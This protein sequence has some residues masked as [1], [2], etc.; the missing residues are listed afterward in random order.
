MAKK[1]GQVMSTEPTTVNRS[2]AVR[3][4]AEL[5]SREDV[6]SLEMTIR[7]RG[8]PLRLRVTGRRIRVTAGTDTTVP[9]DLCC[10][11]EVTQLHPGQTVEF[12]LG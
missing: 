2:T 8:Q 1:V 7:Y 10:H 11:E 12:P 4:A 9:V 6:G 5:M 3:H